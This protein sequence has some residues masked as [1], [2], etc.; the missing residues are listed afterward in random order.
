[1]PF[2][3]GFAFPDFIL[4]DFIFRQAIAASGGCH[5]G[6]AK[7]FAGADEAVEQCTIANT[8]RFFTADFK[9]QSVAYRT[10]VEAPEVLP[11]V[12][13]ICGFDC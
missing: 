11:F 7:P 6:N 2:L 4:F 10:D 12:W 5:Q 3:P 9:H 1:M 8:R 13:V